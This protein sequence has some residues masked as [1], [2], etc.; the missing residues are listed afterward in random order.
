MIALSMAGSVAA[1]ESQ[2]TTKVV[3]IGK[4]DLR[5]DGD[6]ARLKRH[7]SSAAYHVCMHDAQGRFTSPT[8]YDRAEC[9][10]RAMADA[11]LVLDARVASVRGGRAVPG[12]T[13]I[14]DT[15]MAANTAPRP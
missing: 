2:P 12:R 13:S 7:V 8:A 1:A 6:V 5:K 4:L 14:P 3:S 10:R 9:H 11:L 15:E